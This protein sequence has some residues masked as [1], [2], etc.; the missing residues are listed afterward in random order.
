[1]PSL[2][3]ECGR[4]MCDHTAKER[5]QTMAE[6]MR[7]LTAEEEALWCQEPN[8]SENLIKLARNN[9]HLLTA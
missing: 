4:A 8:G 5:G 9:K 3:P 7:P 1:M 6:M 2:C